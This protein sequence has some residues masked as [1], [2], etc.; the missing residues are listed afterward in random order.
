M[1][2]NKKLTALL[3]MYRHRG[4][5]LSAVPARLLMVI[6]AGTVF[7]AAV[8]SQETPP[9]DTVHLSKTDSDT[10]RLE[11]EDA[12]RLSFLYDS[13]DKE[14]WHYIY[15]WN[16]GERTDGIQVRFNG[17][18][19]VLCIGQRLSAI[20]WPEEYDTFLAAKKHI[21]YATDPEEDT[22]VVCAPTMNDDTSQYIW[23]DGS[24]QNGE[25]KVLGR[26]Q[27]IYAHA[28]MQFV[29]QWVQWDPRPIRINL[30]CSPYVFRTFEESLFRNDPRL[31]LDF[32][33]V[34]GIK[35]RREG[36]S[37]GMV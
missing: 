24:W 25:L 23:H 35:K 28:K 21:W 6:W 26:E 10:I 33:T 22:C 7:C 12:L 20:H 4:F 8:Q 1:L 34:S 2:S 18:R 11:F 3:K 16:T 5:R 37:G 32:D 29:N 36:R 13:A 30:Y 19:K 15:R 14:D 27:C 31:T 17:R 9:E